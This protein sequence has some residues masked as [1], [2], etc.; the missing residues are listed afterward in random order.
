M[1]IVVNAV[2]ESSE[3]HIAAMQAAIA[4]M[5]AASRAESGCLDYTFSIEINRPDVI[6]ITERWASLD[7]LTAHFG[8][9]HMAAFQAAMAKYPPVSVRASFFE[10]S[11]I[12]F[13]GG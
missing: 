11:E 7:A 10:A 1:E 5:E 8:Q 6:R 2:I 4:A 3:Q 9:P 12:Q 13:P